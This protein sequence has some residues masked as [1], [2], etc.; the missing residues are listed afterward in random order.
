MTSRKVRRLRKLAVASSRF[1]FIHLI[2]R[3]R[4]RPDA[5]AIDGVELIEHVR[6]VAQA[7]DVDEVTLHLHGQRVKA[8]VFDPHLSHS[9]ARK[10]LTMDLHRNG[11]VLAERL[12]LGVNGRRR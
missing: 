12:A 7:A 10:L 6:P 9:S 2:R 5:R 4:R 1:G 8:A 3:I 11:K